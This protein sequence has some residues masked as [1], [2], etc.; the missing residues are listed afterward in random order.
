MS[1]CIA[2]LPALQGRAS[3]IA[4]SLSW[5]GCRRLNTTASVRLP[6]RRLESRSLHSIRRPP[7]SVA[8]LKRRTQAYPI[9]PDVVA[10]DRLLND[11]AAVFT[12][13]VI[14]PKHAAEVLA[15]W[16]VHAWAFDA[17]DISP[18]MVIVSRLLAHGSPCHMPIGSD[19]CIRISLIFDCNFLE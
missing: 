3:I 14:L 10:S 7:K 4:W 12:R 13:Y 15:L 6:P 19:S 1:W 9:W 16:V 18:F 11:L 8:G 2:S 17:W 5:L